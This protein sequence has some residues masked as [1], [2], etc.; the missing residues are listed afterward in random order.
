MSTALQ[1]SE[2]ETSPAL[3]PLT[4]RLPDSVKLPRVT[5]GFVVLLGVIFWVLSFQP[6]YH[7]DLWGHLAYGKLIWETGTLPAT[8]PFM[9]LAQGVSVVDTAW[10]SQIIGYAAQLRWGLPAIQFLHAA[11]ATACFALLAWGFYRK[12]NSVIATL[13]GLA[14]FGT[15]IW[16]QFAV[17]RPQLAGLLCFVALF[18]L[19][20]W[21]P[22]SRANWVLV[23]VLFALWANLHGSFLVGLL[24]LGCFTLG[25]AID[26]WRRTGLFAATWRDARVRRLFLLTELAAAAVLI[27]PYGLRLYLEVFTFSGNPNLADMI[28]WQPLSIRSSHGLMAALVATA[29]V[30]VYRLSPRRISA[31]EVL[32]LIGF[33]AA[34]LWTTR[35]LIWWAP[36]A[37]MHL[38]WHAHAVAQ[39]LLPAWTAAVASP[40]SGR[41][42]V[43]S[44]TLVWV[45][46]GFTP[47]GMSVMHGK[48]PDLKK[49][50]SR[51]TPLAAVEYL[52]K[53]PPKGL[54]FN[55]MEW[56]DYLQWA[57]PPGLQIFMS[58]QMHLAPPEIWRDYMAVLNG[59]A[60]WED[61]L[62]RYDVNTIVVDK[63]ERRALIYRIREDDSWKRVFEDDRT[64]M[65]ERKQ[66]L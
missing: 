41:W 3:P 44:T 45:F 29:L 40:R 42:T 65:F 54:I 48:I 20:A 39:K 63:P 6:L 66:P 51:E 34:T 27:N 56:G 43:I 50:V 52:R 31:A 1:N 21:R 53:K 24:V 23:P 30:F 57:G 14:V 25:R 47:F 58:S 16:Y 26:V 62:D 2:P 32:L 17:V 37:T 5:A 64:V 33:G 4:D 49:S 13:L 9:P 35:M 28:E 8:E 12:T 18:P 15:L 36:L 10:L 60:S 22:W 59:N 7:T 55:I 46:F 38:V 19:L 11:T 61:T